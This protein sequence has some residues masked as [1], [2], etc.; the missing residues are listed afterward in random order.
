MIRLELPNI[1]FKQTYLDAVKEFIDNGS[2]NE[3]T[4][5]Y[6]KRSLEQFDSEFE[7]FVQEEIDNH[8]N[9]Q[10]EGWVQCSE[11]WIIDDNEK[12][13]GRVSLRHKLNDF[14]KTFG[15]HIGADIIPSQRKKGYATLAVK[16]CLEEAIKIG[17]DKVL[18]TCD[19]DNFRSAKV[20]EKNGGILQDKI[21]QDN[22]TI[23]RRYWISLEK[24]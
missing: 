2:N 8:N 14:L 3:S 23:T 21:N 19:E 16:L 18:I 6:F 24:K 10:S 12:Y 20:I 13:C 9:I 7:K 5:H 1:K 17:L 15:G 11:F 22:G 4:N